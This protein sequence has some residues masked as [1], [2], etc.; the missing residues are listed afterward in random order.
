MGVWGSWVFRNPLTV[1]L[2]V[3]ET[4]ALERPMGSRSAQILFYCGKSD[5]ELFKSR[6]S[7]R[8]QERPSQLD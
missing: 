3:E 6:F 2:Q 4:A 8:C 1:Q 7:V 5:S